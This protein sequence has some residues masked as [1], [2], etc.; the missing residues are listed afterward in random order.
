MP[1]ASFKGCQGRLTA[2]VA[3]SPGTLISSRGGAGIAS[4]RV[5]NTTD[6][7]LQETTPNSDKLM[8]IV[9]PTPDNSNLEQQWVST[10]CVISSSR[11][12]SISPHRLDLVKLT[13]ARQS[14]RK[15]AVTFFASQHSLTIQN[16]E[17]DTVQFQYCAS[18]FAAASV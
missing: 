2:W 5:W 7:A 10:K 4:K 17:A 1:F 13:R 14:Y 9:K 11:V 12:G 18:Y 3:S 16:P 15:G 8:F 6:K